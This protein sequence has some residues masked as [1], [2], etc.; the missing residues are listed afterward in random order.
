[1]LL[2][3]ACGANAN[4]TDRH[5]DTALWK[6]VDQDLSE[7][8]LEMVQDHHASIQRCSRDRKKV[9]KARLMLKHAEKKKRLRIESEPNG[10]HGGGGHLLTGDD[11]WMNSTRSDGPRGDPGDSGRSSGGRGDPGS[12]GSGG[13]RK[14]YD[15]KSYES[16]DRGDAGRPEYGGSGSAKSKVADA[17]A[18][19][20]AAAAQQELVDELEAEEKKQ[21][22]AATKNQVCELRLWG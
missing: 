12:T 22:D 10:S 14:S 6:L 19:A 3:L 5:G 16:G 17:S 9:T 15:T 20:A 11:S 7:A 8:A 2:L 13:R 21:Q 4:V 18:E 1:M